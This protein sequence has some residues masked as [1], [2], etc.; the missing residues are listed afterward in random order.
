VTCGKKKNYP[1]GDVEALETLL[2]L[3]GLVCTGKAWQ[4]I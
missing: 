3:S 4:V 1:L 2:N